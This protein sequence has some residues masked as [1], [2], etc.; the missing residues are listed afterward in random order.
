MQNGICVTPTHV[1]CAPPKEMQNGACVTPTPVT[2]VPPKEMQNGAC[3]TPTPVTCVP[4]KVLQN[5]AC[6]YCPSGQIEYVERCISCK[7]HE[8][9]YLNKCTWIMDILKDEFG[10]PKLCLSTRKL[11]REYTGSCVRVVDSNKKEIDIGFDS[12]G[13]ID[14][15]EFLKLKEPVFVYIWY[16]QSGY[17]NQMGRDLFHGYRWNKDS[18]G[19]Q[20]GMPQLTFVTM[21]SGLNKPIISFSNTQMVT[22]GPVTLSKLGITN[23]KH[24]IVSS[25][26]SSQQ[27]I[28]FIYSSASSGSNE[29][30]LNGSSGVRYITD[31]NTYLDVGSNGRYTDGKYH[32]FVQTGGDPLKDQN[33]L[34]MVDN[35]KSFSYLLSKRIQ[36]NSNAP[37]A[38]GTKLSGVGDGK[39]Y[40]KGDISE[41][42]IF[43]T[44]PF[45]NNN[46]FDLIELY[47]E[48]VKTYNDFGY[49]T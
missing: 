15:G 29:I 20:N 47:I 32:T 1:T 42:I 14:Y 24:C 37:L 35:I 19:A 8:I 18:F 45:S 17:N 25:V 48:N 39:F 30:H 41:F 34:I 26:S 36:T 21:A 38:I 6:D 13:M 22:D 44:E 7:N 49:L 16:D 31:N 43:P 5:G 46:F 4:P 40:L 10:K 23:Q 12:K 28:Q 3:V 33:D 2:C 11:L 9:I 27:G